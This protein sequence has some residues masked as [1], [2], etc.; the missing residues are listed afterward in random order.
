MIVVVGMVAVAVS[1]TA[2]VASRGT[3]VV[4]AVVTTVLVAVLV[5]GTAVVVEVVLAVMVRVLVEV[6]SIRS[7]QVTDVGYTAGVHVQRPSLQT[8]V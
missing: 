5:T 1:V 8:T 7:R 2:T 6:V 4:V 3:T